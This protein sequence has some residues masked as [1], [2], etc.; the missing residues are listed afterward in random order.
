MALPA[1]RDRDAGLKAWPALETERDGS[2]V[3]RAANGYTKRANSVQCL[4][5]AD[6]EDACRRGSSTLRTGSRRGNL[7]PS[8][9]SRRWRARR[10][11]LALDAAGWS[12]F[13]HSHR[14]RDDLAA[15]C[16]RPTSGR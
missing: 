4:D 5:P 10:P 8:S 16:R 15:G 2:W 12:A 6:D 9:A 11:S 3:L 1:P 13:D 7:P 14:P